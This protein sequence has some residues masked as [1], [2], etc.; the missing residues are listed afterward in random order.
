M[1]VLKERLIESAVRPLDDNAEMRLAATRLLDELMT[2]DAP[3][4]EKAIARWDAVDAKPGHPWWSLML[5]VALIV[6]S[7]TVGLRDY[8]EIG[9]YVAWRE[10]IGGDVIATSPP[11]PSARFTENLTHEQRLLI[12]DEAALARREALWQLHP[13]DPAYFVEYSIEYANKSKSLPPDFLETARRI[14]PENAWFTWFAASVEAKGALENKSVDRKEDDG[15][16]RAVDTWAVLDQARVDRASALIA[17]ARSQPKFDNYANAMLLKRQGIFPARSLIDQMD[18]LGQISKASLY[19]NLKLMDVVFLLVGRALLAAEAGD[20][21]GFREASEQGQLFLQQ[22]AGSEA[23]TLLAGVVAAGYVASFSKTFSEGAEK[24]GLEREAAHW[25]AI[26][27]ASSARRAAI[28]ANTFLVDGKVADPRLIGGMLFGNGFELAPR[29]VAHPPALTDADLEAGRMLDHE[30]LSRF[31]GYLTWSVMGISL[32][33]VASYRFRVAPLVW[34]LAG[35]MEQLLDR[36]DWEWILGGGVILP[37]AYVMA[38]NRLTSLGGHSFGM[39][40]NAMLLPAGHFFGLIVLWLLLPL[41]IARWR[42]ATTARALT[43]PRAS[44][45]GW[46]AVAAAVAF[47]PLIGWAGISRSFPPFWAGWIEHLG[48]VLSSIRE[49]SGL[50]WLAICVLAIPVFWLGFCLDR[51]L[52]SSSL[53]LLQHA[54]VARILV[55]TFP[56]AMLLIALATMAFKASEKSWFQRDNMNRWDTAKPGWTAYEAEVAAQLRKEMLELL[57]T[58]DGASN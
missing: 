20:V 14:D 57:A 22:L 40:G 7:A 11:P 27:D 41:Q 5:W 8:Q 17:E 50:W 31:Y 58:G 26:S 15:T 43:F 21:T 42:L 35:R 16:V 12:G 39:I 9:R 32:L 53:R 10:W 28:R 3:G 2:E 4:A 30:I 56:V 36:R 19:P 37:L 6:V 13:Q 51:A 24:L 38:V 48:I 34:R 33:A 54:T 1:S 44:W 46:I 45:V 29:T 23:E 25:K 18:G 55:K 52:M 47:V 49:N